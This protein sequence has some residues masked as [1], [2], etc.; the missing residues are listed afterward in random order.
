MKKYATIVFLFL[1]F[2]KSFS[3]EYYG[4][5]NDPL[6]ETQWNLDKTSFV[7]YWDVFKGD[8]VVIAILDVGFDLSHPDLVD[9]YYRDISANIA[10]NIQ[11]QPIL[12]N[13][14]ENRVFVGYSK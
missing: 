14:D 13:E 5:T 2:S 9:N 7:N 11:T 12:F 4:S 6:F 1:C 3:Q 10:R 8:G